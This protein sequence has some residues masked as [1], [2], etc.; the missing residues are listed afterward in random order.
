MNI[1]IFIGG[2]LLLCFLWAGTTRGLIMVV[3]TAL[4]GGLLLAGGTVKSILSGGA[5]IGAIPLPIVVVFAAEVMSILGGCM[6]LKR[7]KYKYA[8]IAMWIS[9]VLSFAACTL[10][11]DGNILAAYSHGGMD[12][13]T[14]LKI[15]PGLLCVV[16]FAHFDA[17][18]RYKRNDSVKPL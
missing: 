4:I 14:V 6:Y 8:L 2:C 18:R 15:M 1:V 17:Y 3:G 5:E 7:S 16:L 13:D 10:D 12:S 11:P 9:F